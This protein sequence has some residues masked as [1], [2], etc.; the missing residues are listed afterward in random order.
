MESQLC[1]DSL[2]NLL[3]GKTSTA[4]SDRKR[5]VVAVVVVVEAV[6]S[7]AARFLFVGYHRR[8]FRLS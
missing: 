7:D 8:S 6:P 4:L 1:I 3:Q 2:V 5:V